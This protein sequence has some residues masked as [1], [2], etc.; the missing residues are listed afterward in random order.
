MFSFLFKR[1]DNIHYTRWRI[2]KQDGNYLVYEHKGQGK[3]EPYGS[4][5][6]RLPLFD[7]EIE[8]WYEPPVDPSVYT[9]TSLIKAHNAVKI[10]IREEEM[11]KLKL[12]SEFDTI[13]EDEEDEE[14]KSAIKVEPLLKA[15]KKGYEW[16]S[17]YRE[18]HNPYVANGLNWLFWETGWSHHK[19]VYLHDLEQ[20]E[21][22]VVA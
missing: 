18:K 3:Y 9:F 21:N 7:E 1:D 6:K 8:E 11:K 16:F 20:R 14:C 19:M 15:Y 4:V 22:R 5:L 10:I 2:Y 12:I 17:P 13:S